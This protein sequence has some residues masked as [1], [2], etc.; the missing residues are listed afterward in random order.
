MSLHFV[1]APEQSVRQFDR[2]Y[3]A[4][5][6][7]GRLYPLQGA[8]VQDLVLWLLLLALAGRGVVVA[9]V[10]GGRRRAL[11]TLAAP[12]AAH[13]L[14]GDTDDDRLARSLADGE[15]RRHRVGAV[16]RAMERQDL[17]GSGGEGG[18][19]ESLRS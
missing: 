13:L 4:P 10:A 12:A 8:G 16:V 2:R 7:L 17:L 11:A 15:L 19:A 18:G 9:L 1:P 3:S 14:S 6:D 5:G